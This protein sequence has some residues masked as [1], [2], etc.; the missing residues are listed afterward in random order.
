MTIPAV[1]SPSAGTFSGICTREGETTKTGANS[2]WQEVLYARLRGRPYPL[3]VFAECIVPAASIWSGA[4]LWVTAFREAGLCAGDR[5]VLSLPSSPE[6]AQIL[7]AALWESLTV[8]F[9]P[10]T[11]DL[12]A[13]AENAENLDARVVFAN[14]DE[15]TPSVWIPA[16]CEGPSET[17]PP[18]R[19]SRLPRTPEARF[20]LRTSG[21]TANSYRSAPQSPNGRWI[22]LSDTN[23][24]S[25]LD[26][27]LP[28]LRLSEERTRVLSVLPYHHTFGLILDLLP[29]LLS[30]AEILRDPHGGRSPADL[31]ALAAEN[32]TT[33][34]NTV[35]L[36]LK[37]LLKE[38]G[39]A[40][41]LRGL[42]GGIVGGAPVDAELAA[43]LRTTKLRAGYG[44]T[45][46]S[47][48]IALGEPGEWPD[49]NYL[50]RPLGCTVTQDERGTLHFRG[51]NQHY[52]LWTSANGLQISDDNPNRYCNTGDVVRRDEVTGQLFFCGRTDDAFKL[53]NGRR[54]EA[55]VLETQLRAAFPTLQEV[56]LS[57][58]DGETLRLF[59]TRREDAIP[60]AAPTLPQYQTALG[61]LGPRLTAIS[62]VQDAE[63]VRTPKGTVNRHASL[64]HFT[65]ADGTPL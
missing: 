16:G 55:G 33:H 1:P 8:A 39:G 14:R 48:G 60:S 63:W 27:H 62:S 64:A 23:I 59:V 7:V 12:A 43:F 6:F 41:F 25:V 61:S 52:G 51:A 30:G 38:P 57:S 26:S 5:I 31:L 42:S 46:A 19:E 47:P 34:L 20:L 9:V 22:A 29:A 50:G 37:R 58:P 28:A 17:M 54:I 11:T 10:P 65:R 40:E 56:L 4:R 21:T 15:I 45:E 44:Q 24:W 49:A 53:N 18:L 3:F 13:L 2:R 36:T 32:G 35:P